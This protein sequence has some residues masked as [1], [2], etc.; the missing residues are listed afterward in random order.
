MQNDS[1]AANPEE[2]IASFM[3]RTHYEREAKV[4]ALIS[5]DG[6]AFIVREKRFDH[7]SDAVEYARV[8]IFR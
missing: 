2:G 3:M 1:P 8:L 6:R 4:K 7:Y 5:G